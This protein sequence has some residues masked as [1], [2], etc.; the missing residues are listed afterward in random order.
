MY[1]NFLRSFFVVSATS[2]FIGSL[3][4]VPSALAA[5]ATHI[6]ISEVQLGVSGSPTN[7]FIE[8]YNPTIQTSM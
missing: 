4:F 5:T 6:V 3:L 8:L 1:K 7:E 2:V